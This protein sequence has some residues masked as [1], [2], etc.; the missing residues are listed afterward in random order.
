MIPVEL[1]GRSPFPARG[2]S[3]ALFLSEARG[4]RLL[5]A[6]FV[7]PQA[8]AWADLASLALQKDMTLSD[9]SELDLS[10]TPPLSHLWHPF[11]LAARLAEKL[12]Q[13]EVWR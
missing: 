3:V 4:G 8:A 11:L 12:S 9:F 6:Q 1:G 10:Y 2:R 5:G 13:R 7:G